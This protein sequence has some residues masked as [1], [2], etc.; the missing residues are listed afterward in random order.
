MAAENVK[1]LHIAGNLQGPKGDKGDP[2]LDGAVGPQG[3][4]GDSGANG[5]TPI[6]GVDYFTEEDINQIADDVVAE[7]PDYALAS[8]VD[9][10]QDRVI[11]LEE[12][13]IVKDGKIAIKTASALKG[14]TF[15]WA[16]DADNAAWELTEN[17]VAILPDRAVNWL[18]PNAD[19]V[20]K[21]SYKVDVL[22]SGTYYMNVNMSSPNNA[23]DSFHI[24]VDGEFVSTFS[25]GDASGDKKW[26]RVQWASFN[27]T[28]GKHTISIGAREDG[29]EIN[30][31]VLTTNPDEQFTDGVLDDPETATDEEVMAML[32]DL[33]MLPAVT[34]EGSVITDE[35]GDI[36]LW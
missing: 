11:V 29:F 19:N 26:R 6:K 1:K 18:D 7:L 17:G 25:P 24:Y 2:G 22:K 33:G 15:A 14:F 10:L 21:I 27:F 35:N 5:Y 23:A 30:R 34:S 32:M 28:K 4:K 12:W 16:E 31:I 9:D 3:P 13:I 8:T 36:V 20:P